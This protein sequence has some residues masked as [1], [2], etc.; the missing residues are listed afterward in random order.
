MNNLKN[1]K[2]LLCVTGSI[3]A[4]KACEFIRLLKKQQCHV[5]VVMSK[6]S[7]N[8]IGKL[9]LSALSDNI[10]LTDEGQTG[11]EHV[12]F[13]IDFDVI[14]ILPA[15]ANIICKTSSGIADDIV[16]T[17]LSICEQPKLFVPAMNFR[18]WQSKA[19]QLAVETLKG[20]DCYVMNPEEGH[21][22]SLH[23]GE[24][25]LPKLHDVM[26]QLRALFDIKLP[27]KGKRVIVTAG[28]TREAIDP[29][30]FISNKSSGKM[31]YALAQE[32]RNLGAQVELISGP[33][34]ID[35][36]SEVNV[37]QIETAND[38]YD[39]ISISLDV[40]Y[41]IMCAAVSDYSPQKKSTTKIKR[42]N[43]DMMLKME[44]T[45]D[46]IKSIS[47]KTNA[48]I[49]AFALETCN[50]EEN[51]IKKMMDKKTDYIALNHP[52]KDGCGIESNFNSI[53]L[54]N[55]NGDKKIISKDRKDRIAKKM[56]EYV[57]KDSVL[58]A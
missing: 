4:Y 34:S 39:A 43:K 27:L 47:K 36:P 8:F 14:V 3:A 15:T 19:T 16:S 1:K 24:G 28:P 55:K 6:S 25:R 23:K 38:M 26:N 29:V 37:T 2:V 45:T 40:D 48:I 44:P 21:L 52:T 22:A 31:G 46:I 9:S 49:I 10:V 50:S 18:M 13:A 53:I 54:F 12:K 41:I 30:R 51:A 20:N 7:E 57:I 5:Q 33:V 11:L 17:I 56:L 32:A 58:N 35:P 42:D